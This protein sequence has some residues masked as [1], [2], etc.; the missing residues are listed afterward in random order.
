MT[1]TVELGDYRFTFQGTENV[2][3][4]NYDAIRAKV[5]VTQ[6]GREVAVLQPERRN[7]WVSQQALAE[8]SLGVNWKR[9][10]LATM[11]EELGRGAWSLRLQV[12]PLMSF[13]W[14]GATLMALGG[15]WAACDR[16]YRV[17]STADE[18]AAAATSLVEPA[19]GS[20]T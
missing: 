15:L 3:G 16:R 12:R 9:D 20:A 13:I 14:L 18:R 4:P 17:R 11:G 10:L 8:A 19:R 7:Y 1:Q 5:Q 2:E 6:D